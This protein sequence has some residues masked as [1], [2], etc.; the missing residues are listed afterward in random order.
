MN[1][2][3]K[4]SMDVV[5]NFTK[6]YLCYMMDMK[7]KIAVNF[8]MENV[9]NTSTSTE[10]SDISEI[11]WNSSFSVNTSLNSEENDSCILLLPLLKY[12]INGRKKHRVEHYLHVVDSWTDLEFK[13]HLRVERTTAIQLIDELRESNFIPSH[14][15]GTKPI[16][17]KLSFLI[18]LWHMANTE[19]LRTISDRFDVSISS[20]FRVIRRV[21]AWILTKLDNVIKWPQEQHIEYVCHQFYTKRGISNVIGAIDCTHIKIEKPNVENARDYC[22]RK[23]YFSINLQAVVDADMKF[24]NIYC[25]QPGSLHDA[26]VL[27]KSV[28]YN[29]A[30]E[31]RE[32]IFPNEKFII[33]DSAYPSLQWLVPPFRDNGYLTPHQTEFN[34][35]HSSTRMVVEKAFGYLKGRFRRIKFFSEYR[36]MSFITNTVVAAC[37]LHNLCLN[38]N[39]DNFNDNNVEIEEP[40]DN[41]NNDTNEDVN[42]ELQVDRRMQVFREIFGQE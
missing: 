19:P 7:Q 17:A 14:S 25:G 41:I 5:F 16:E 20:V 1:T 31:H 40:N 33:G 2:A 22:N 36:K 24:T 4:K 21:T 35:I 28:L 30:N 3:L 11:S 23:K 39:D 18:F 15:F 32:V 37:I 8:L 38:C 26:R 34:F 10:S 6:R 27:R 29:S 13:E 9:L 12:L 42:C